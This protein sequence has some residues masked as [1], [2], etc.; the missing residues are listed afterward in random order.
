MRCKLLSDVLTSYRLKSF[1]KPAVAFHQHLAGFCFLALLL[2][3]SRAWCDG[4]KRFFSEFVLAV[5]RL[6]LPW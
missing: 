6:G 5:A 1:G 4:G 3:L 2:P